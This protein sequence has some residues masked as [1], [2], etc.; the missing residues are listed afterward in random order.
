MKIPFVKMHGVGNDFVVLDRVGSQTELPELALLAR[1]VNDRRFGIGGDGLILAEPAE[2]GRFRM[3]MFNPDG[4][5]S[6]MCGNGVRCVAR[7]L[8]DRGYLSSSSLELHTGAGLLELELQCDHRVRVD[9]GKARLTKGEIGMTGAAEDRFVDQPVCDNP[10]LEGTAVGMGNPHLVIFVQDL[11]AI[12]LHALGPRLEHNPLFP[13]RVNVQFAQVISRRA[14]RVKSWERG[15]GATLACGTGACATAAAAKLT[16]RSEPNVRVDLP[17][18]SLDI[19]V[20]D[21]WTVHM[22]G[23]AETVFEGEWTQPD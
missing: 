6:E 16:D 5:E 9:M 8:A 18:G 15:A 22:T 13:N 19:E 7:L 23:P 3:R 21:D 17:G 10:T 12:G 14:I 11:D 2:Q 20:A 4:S 1:N